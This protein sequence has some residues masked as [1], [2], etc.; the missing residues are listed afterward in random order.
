[1][2]PFRSRRSTWINSK[3]PC[4]KVA[5]AR[6]LLESFPP[7]NEREL[8]SAD[9]DTSMCRELVFTGG[10]ASEAAK[11]HFQAAQERVRALPVSA[12]RC[13]ITWRLWVYQ[14]NRGPVS[15]AQE[16]AEELMVLG[17]QVGDSELILNA[18][19]AMWSTALMRG[20]FGA[21]LAHTRHGMSVCGSGASGSLAMTC[22]CTL[23]DSHLTDHHPAVCAG[24]FSAF[25]DAVRGRHRTMARGLDAALTHA[26]DVGHPFTIALALM[27]AGGAFAAVSDAG[28]ARVRAA[29]G[30]AVA[31]LHGFQAMEA[32]AA[33][34]EGWALV[35]LGDK[36]KGM[37]C[38]D[39]GLEAS[40]AAG[41][42]LFRPFHLVLAASAKVAVGSLDDAADCLEEAFAL[43]ERV[44]DRLA[45]AEMHRLRGEIAA[46]RKGSLE[47][48]RL[49][50]AD[51][52]AAHEIAT[53]Q[54]ADFWASR[55][56]DSLDKMRR[57]VVTELPTPAE[58][59][60]R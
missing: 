44:G 33:V 35:M 26:R 46:L 18:H 45:L 7:G 27:H 17:R 32:W 3:R 9:A 25:A 37:Q 6:R 42:I 4:A 50:I 52:N 49:A 47:N 24:S 59:A 54:G 15:K 53:S 28:R 12:E 41:L 40:A 48:R 22:G 55:A 11:E 8:L 60:K 57:N 1:M 2:A 14:I 30:R 19:H 43:T 38:L 58:G 5:A 20:D 13:R 16:L 39:Q 51:L 21:V 29:E 56:A 36:A 23:H 34:Y 31:H 10:L